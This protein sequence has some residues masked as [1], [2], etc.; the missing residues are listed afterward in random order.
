MDMK[1]YYKRVR[2]IESTLPDEVVLISKETPEGGKA[3]RFT[4]APRHTA[5]RLIAEG[6][7]ERASDADSAAFIETTREQHADELRK[8]AAASI[9]VS[10]VTEEQVRALS[11]GITAKR[12]KP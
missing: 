1:K 6:V 2:E 9:Q 10:V 7:A 5:A 11:G 3:G 8:R 12:S 4:E